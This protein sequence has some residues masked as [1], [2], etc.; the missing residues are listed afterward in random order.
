[1]NITAHLIGSNEMISDNPAFQAAHDFVIGYERKM[2]DTELEMSFPKIH[3]IA[4]ADDIAI[5]TDLIMI[6]PRAMNSPESKDEVDKILRATRADAPTSVVVFTSEVWM[7]ATKTK[8]PTD[9]EI[10]KIK[11]QSI[12]QDPTRQEA[13]LLSMF[14]GKVKTVVM[15]EILRNPK[16]FGKM[17]VM[18]SSL[19]G[20]FI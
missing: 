2:L 8:N 17:E 5:P 20:R 3:V 18:G 6:D 12:Q 16:R 14:C 15:Y 10:E 1:M 4:Y 19:T 9:E 7:K 11:Q 13:F